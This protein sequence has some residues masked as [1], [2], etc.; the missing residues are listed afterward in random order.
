LKPNRVK[1]TVTS[2]MHFIQK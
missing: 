2:K 1:L